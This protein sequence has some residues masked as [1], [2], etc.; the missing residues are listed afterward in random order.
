[1]SEEFKFYTVLDA[2]I[3]VE[4]SMATVRNRIKA[5]VI[6]AVQTRLGYLITPEEIEDYLIRRGPKKG[7]G[8]FRDS[9]LMPEDQTTSN[10]DTT[11]KEEEN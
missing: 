5:G 7:R 2:A 3:K 6:K 9:M 4:E 11:N 8:Y 1:M 10:D